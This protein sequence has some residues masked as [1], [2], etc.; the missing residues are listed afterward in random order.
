MKLL[1]L[2]CHLIMLVTNGVCSAD[3]SESANNWK[4]TRLFNPTPMDLASERKGRIM[5]YDGLTDKTVNKALDEHFDRI[6]ALMFTR[7]IVTSESGAPLRDPE[8]AGLVFEDD[9]CD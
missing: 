1:I 8:T 6:E 5:I 3:E 2:T 9:G 4:M 7:T